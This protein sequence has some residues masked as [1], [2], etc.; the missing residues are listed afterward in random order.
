MSYILDNITTF[1]PV[2][3]I[4]TIKSFKKG[5]PQRAEFVKRLMMD[6]KRKNYDMTKFNFVQL[7]DMIELIS[8]T[9]IEN[10]IIFQNFFDKAISLNQYSDADLLNDFEPFTK[11]IHV[12]ALNGCLQND[13]ITKKFIVLLTDKIREKSETKKSMPGLMND[14]LIMI[15]WTLIYHDSLVARSTHTPNPQLPRLLERLS[16]FKR[17]QKLSDLELIQLYQIQQW[18]DFKVA[19]E[20]IPPQFQNCIP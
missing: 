14:N 3:L 9:D 18:I 16:E 17:V 13:Q 8:E 2:E 10:V 15:I 1:E 20:R 7:V 4:K 11:L 19:N 6:L 12:F 5:S